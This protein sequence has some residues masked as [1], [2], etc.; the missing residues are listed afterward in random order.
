MKKHPEHTDPDAR[1]T[2]ECC[3]VSLKTVA[4]ATRLTVLVALA[5]GSALVGELAN[6]LN[7][8]QSLLSH[9]LKTLR[10]GQFVVSTR[11][12]KAVRY[13]LAP[14]IHVSRHD[15]DHFLD[16]GCCLIRLKP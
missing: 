4:D 14:N 2:G 6:Q 8:E 7:I 1:T 5:N 15:K 10:D 9:H 3:A 16:L 11:E 12:G 13:A